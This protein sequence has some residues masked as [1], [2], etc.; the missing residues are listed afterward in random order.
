MKKYGLIGYPLTHSFSKQFF[1]EKFRKEKIHAAYLNFEIDS[2][3]HISTIIEEN[4]ELSGLNVTIPYKELII[5]VLDKLDRE[6]EEIAAVNT[7]KIIRKQDK[8]YLTGFNTDIWGFEHS[9]KPFLKNHHKSALILGTGG[10]SK[11]VQYVLKKLDINFMTV[12]TRVP[13]ENS[14]NYHDLT[15]QLMTDHTIIINT[16]PLGTF[17]HINTFPNIPYEHITSNHLLY[18]LVYN[19]ELTTFLQ[20]GKQQGAIIKNGYEMLVLQALKSYEIWEQ[21]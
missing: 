3:D 18:D 2:V 17:P 5:P 15:K 10:A 19:P 12:T 8:I 20:K 11:A 6:A 1:T 21:L 13:S 16:T 4:P 9:L 7:I 14:V